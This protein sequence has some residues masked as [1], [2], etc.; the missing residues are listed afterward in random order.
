[1]FTPKC[2]RKALYVEL[3]KHLGEVFKPIAEQNE[4]R[5]EEGHLLLDHV[6]VLTSILPKHSVSRGI[7]F[8]KGKKA[9]QMARVHGELKKSFAVQHFWCEASWCPQWAPRNAEFAST[10]ATK[11]R[12]S[13]DWI[14]SSCGSN[15]PP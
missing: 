6:H 3:R 5:I 1:M 2:R 10:S 14:S 11:K 8:I 4:S 12:K 15:L 7:G 13:G 9:I